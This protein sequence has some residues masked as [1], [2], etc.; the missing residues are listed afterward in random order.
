MPTIT[1]FDW[2]I[3][4]DEFKTPVKFH[5]LEDAINFRDEFDPHVYPDS[6]GDHLQLSDALNVSGGREIN[7]TLSD[8]L[9]LSDEIWRQYESMSDILL[10]TDWLELP[11]GLLYDELGFDEEISGDSGPGI[12]DELEFTEELTYQVDLTRTLPETLTLV[13]YFHGVINDPWTPA[14]PIPEERE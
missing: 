14:F 1:M 2:L 6:I 11:N 8:D 9:I 7:V 12:T 10:L 3:L 4:S 13:D 5:S